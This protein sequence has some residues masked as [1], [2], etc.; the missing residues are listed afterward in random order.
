MFFSELESFYVRVSCLCFVYTHLA[1]GKVIYQPREYK[2][3]R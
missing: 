2:K 1:G 3:E